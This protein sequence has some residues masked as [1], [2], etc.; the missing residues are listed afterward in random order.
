M[1]LWVGAASRESSPGRGLLTG[2]ELRHLRRLY[3]HEPLAQ[4]RDA[5]RAD[6]AAGRGGEPSGRRIGR[7]AA[8]GMWPRLSRL[9]AIAGR[10][11]AHRAEAVRWM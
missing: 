5:A 4:D 9:R 10:S 11:G 6:Q 7:A 1:A 8:Q 3:G 2:G